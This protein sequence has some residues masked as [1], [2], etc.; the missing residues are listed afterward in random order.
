MCMY[1]KMSMDITRVRYVQDH[2]R[3]Q[4]HA[5][6]H[7]KVLFHVHVNVFVITH[8]HTTP[9]KHIILN[10]IHGIPLSYPSE[11][12]WNFAEFNADSA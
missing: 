6:E 12:P 4:V 8:V 7:I 3:E 2:V 11:I 9:Q 1:M 10:F 5:H